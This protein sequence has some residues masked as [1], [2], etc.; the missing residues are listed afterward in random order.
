[1]N[2]GAHYFGQS[3]HEQTKKNSIEADAQILSARDEFLAKLRQQIPETADRP[4]PR[5]RLKL[6]LPPCLPRFLPKSPDSQ[7]K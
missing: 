4:P 1:M 5:L 6:Q 7:F 3:H 2:P